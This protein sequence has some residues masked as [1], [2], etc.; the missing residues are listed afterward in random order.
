MNSYYL[1]IGALGFIFLYAVWGCSNVNKD[2]PVDLDDEAK[3]VRDNIELV[4]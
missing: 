3:M 2:I 4:D 1:I